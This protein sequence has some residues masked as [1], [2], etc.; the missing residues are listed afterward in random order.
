MNIKSTVA[1]ILSVSLEI[2]PSDGGAWKW[3]AQVQTDQGTIPLDGKAPFGKI[4][5]YVTEALRELGVKPNGKVFLSY[6]EE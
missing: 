4:F 1:T 6:I 3:A 5:I 2:T